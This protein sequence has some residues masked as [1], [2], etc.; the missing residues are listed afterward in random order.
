VHENR[1]IRLNQIELGS[2]NHPLSLVTLPLSLVPRIPD[3]LTLSTE[4]SMGTKKFC[5]N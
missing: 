4:K 5:L 2:L 1:D 3:Y